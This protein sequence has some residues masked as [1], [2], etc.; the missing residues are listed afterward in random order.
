M[1]KVNREQYSKEQFQ[2]R[3]AVYEKMECYQNLE[4][5]RFALCI[6]DPFDVLTLVFF[7]RAR[8]GSILL[9]H[10]ETPKEKAYSMAADA[11]CIGLLYGGA[12]QF[13]SIEGEALIDT[14][15]SL[16]QYSSGTTG[17]PKLI[18]RAWT[19]ID[20]EIEAYNKELACEVDETPIVLAP[21]SHSYGLICGTL[22]ALARGSEP[23][24]VT[25][26]NPKFALNI[27]RE[28][29]KHIV[30]AVPLM[31]HIMGS[32][33]QGVFQFHKVMTSG[34][35]LPKEL[36]HKLKTM[37]TFMMQ[38]YGCS[39][40]GCISICKDMNSHLDL[41]H[42]LEH[43]V[44]QTSEEED[45]PEEII[46][47]IGDKVIY[48][49][50]LGYKSE[51]GLHFV[52]RMDDVINVSGLKVFPLEVEETMLRL[53]GIK[54]AVVYRGKHP[55]MGEIVK[56]QVVAKEGMDANEIR[57]WCLAQLPPYKVPHEVLCVTEIPKN[58]TGK[59]SRKLLEM[60]DVTV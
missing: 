8:G 57:E 17:A 34:S 12:E 28:V 29:P 46:V 51:R 23:I 32:F 16:F 45:D 1:L 5:K 9:I 35:P 39:E 11:S 20:R 52:G 48:T 41:G 31:L 26:K 30:Y 44:V 43:A 50:D 36:F 49:Q 13:Q 14:T 54:E 40:A 53:D 4:G 21:V 55:V 3:I 42:P 38:Q 27:I 47:T 10:G 15:P 59:V 25:N 37:T 22:S 60:G 2:A 24:I 33:P 19:D 6:A 7:L 18:Q 58:T 56:A